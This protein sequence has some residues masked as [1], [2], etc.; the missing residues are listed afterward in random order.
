[1][2]DSTL[3]KISLFTA[4][5][6]LVGLFFISNNLSLKENPIITS[7]DL[8]NSI[9]VK[10]VINHISDYDPNVILNIA[11]C[12]ELKVTLF[13]TDT[14]FNKG[15]PVEVTGTLTEYKGNFELIADEV[16]LLK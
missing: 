1:M 5:L 15:D 12:S 13:N 2:D 9:K 3:L 16:K 7:D 10:G 6:G 4:L 14:V 11:Y 8:D